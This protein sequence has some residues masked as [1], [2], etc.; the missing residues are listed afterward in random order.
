VPQPWN[1][2]L[3][4]KEKAA[5]LKREQTAIEVE[6]KFFGKAFSIQSNAPAHAG[7]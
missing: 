1:V 5:E 4:E 6:W 7:I 2:K 3:E